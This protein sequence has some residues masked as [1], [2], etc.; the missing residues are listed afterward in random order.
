[1][2][3]S[4]LI[5]YVRKSKGGNALKLNLS[6]EALNKAERYKSQGGE[7]FIGLIIHL[8]R[9]NEVIEG[10]RECTSVCQLS[11]GEPVAA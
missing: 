5:G 1:M 3:R 2:Q 4:E 8:G 10:E 11:D 9:V 7:D 6:A